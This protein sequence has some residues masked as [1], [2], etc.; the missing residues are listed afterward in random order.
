MFVPAIHL[1]LPESFDSSSQ[2]FPVGISF[3][4]FTQLAYLVDCYRGI[5]SKSSPLS[6][7]AYVLFFPHL[8]AGPILRHA[9]SIPEFEH[10]RQATDVEVVEGIELFIRGMVRK[11]LVADPLGAYIDPLFSSIESGS[12]FGMA[13]SW[14][15]IVCYA[16]Q[17]YLDFSGYSMMAVGLARM[18]GYRIPINFD[19][20]YR[21]VG[22]IDFWRRWH[23]SLSSFLRDY[24]Y[25]P[26]GGSRRGTLMK[27]RNLLITMALGG[28]WHGST[29]SFAIWGLLH[30]LLLVFEHMIRGRSLTRGDSLTDHKSL[31][32]LVQLLTFGLVVWAWV[33]FRIESLDAA[34]RFWG[35]LLGVSGDFVIPSPKTVLI[36]LLIGFLIVVFEQ[37]ART[38]EEA[39][40]SLS[41]SRRSLILHGAGLVVALMAVGTSAE[42]LYARF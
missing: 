12:S 31:R 19:A 41:Q 22:I 8:I 27:Y 37:R 24:L 25:I 7:A 30:G 20:P 2:W 17:L 33:P 13:G 6:F 36:P 3:F 9:E 42:Y 5:A 29:L 38:T 4:S 10:G 23:M 15:L 32:L 11:T 40:A 16:F 21:A 18:L 28:L 39:V 35:S 34:L 1:L 14:L 26:L